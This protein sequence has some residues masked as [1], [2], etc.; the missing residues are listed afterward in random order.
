MSQRPIDKDWEALVRVTH[1]NEAMERGRLNTALKAIKS[2]W[3]EEGGIPADL[4]EEIPRRAQAYHEM[5]PQMTL[6][7]TALAVHWKRV[8]AQRAPQKGKSVIDQMRREE[9]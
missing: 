6:T 8:V 9:S 4:H 5:W 3:A 1:A 2:A 7:P